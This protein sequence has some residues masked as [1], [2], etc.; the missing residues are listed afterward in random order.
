[1]KSQTQKFFLLLIFLIFQ[2][3]SFSDEISSSQLSEVRELASKSI[4]NQNFSKALESYDNL[5]MRYP[6]NLTIANDIAVIL[7]GMGRLEEARSILEKAMLKNTEI[8]SAFINLREILARQ[9]SISYTKALKRTPP[10]NILA[11]RS[12]GLDATNQTVILSSKAVKDQVAL[13]PEMGSDI[14]GVILVE[15]EDEIKNTLSNWANSWSRKNFSSYISFYSKDFKNSRFKSK[16]SWSKYRK[17]RVTKKKRISIKIINPTI[18][19]LNEK[20]AQVI[21]TQKYKSGNLKL[22]TLKKMIMVKSDKDW[23]II[24]EGTK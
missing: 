6:D 14:P 23:K 20:K 22:S 12:E 9:A 13:L 18:S 7:A 24:F 10:S 8:N 15:T 1:M 21:F 4:A 2:K 5:R 17:P 16:E 19:I 11:L 3:L